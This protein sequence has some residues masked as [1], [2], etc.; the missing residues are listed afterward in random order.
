M[1]PLVSFYSMQNS[2][3][4]IAEAYGHIIGTTRPFLSISMKRSVPLFVIVTAVITCFYANQKAEAQGVLLRGIGAVNESVGGTA[5][6]M[7]LDANGAL[8]W[9]PATISALP[10]NEMTFSLGLFQPQS[11]V[12]SSG[13]VNGNLVSGSTKGEPI[14]AALRRSVGALTSN[15][16]SCVF[17]PHPS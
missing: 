7:P 8:Y 2:S 5:T 16:P 4:V 13:I 14:P 11:R 17:S 3:A 15:F 10:K 1:F 9:N 6:A 12:E